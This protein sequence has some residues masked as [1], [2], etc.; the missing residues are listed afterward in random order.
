[1]LG[2]QYNHAVDMWSLGC[3]IFELITGKPLFPGRDENE[4]IEYFIIT[5]GKVPVEMLGGAKKYK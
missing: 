4:M 3:I 2:I 5:V 1:M